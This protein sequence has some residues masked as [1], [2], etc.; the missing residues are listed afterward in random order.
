MYRLEREE[1]VRE[2][3]RYLWGLLA[4]QAGFV[5]AFGFLSFGRFVSH[6]TGFGSQVGLALAHKDFFFAFQMLGFPI[7]YMLGSFLNGLLTIARIERN[8]KPHYELVTALFPVAFTMLLFLG[9]QGVFG[10]FG[11]Q[12]IY[13]RDFVFLYV[14]SFVCGLQNGC[15][16]T[17]TKGQVRTTH[18]T[19]ITTDLGT[20]LAR[21]LG[22]KLRSPERQLTVDTNVTRV[23]TF[24]AFSVG[25]VASVLA[26]TKLGHR[27]LTV[28]LFTSLAVLAA[29]QVIEARLEAEFGPQ[30]PG[31]RRPSRKQ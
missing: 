12:L 19:G 7:F 30:L 8:E 10:R 1:F 23:V 20:D 11:E 26:S 24:A 28:P 14:L 27:A 5:N 16:A 3:Y 15:F 21:L 17:L 9:L 25:S 18:L 4:F 22:G 13:V 31:G 2:P 6:V 29:V